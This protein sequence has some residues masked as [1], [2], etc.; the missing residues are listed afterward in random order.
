M[1]IGF[2]FLITIHCAFSCAEV[3][4][5]KEWIHTA[6]SLAFHEP[7]DTSK[8]YEENLEEMVQKNLIW[9]SKDIQKEVLNI[10]QDYRNCLME[11]EYDDINELKTIVNKQYEEAKCHYQPSSYFRYLINLEVYSKKMFS[12]L[13]NKQTLYAYIAEKNKNFKNEKLKGKEIIKFFDF[14]FENALELSKKKTLY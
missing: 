8:N 10:I 11:K 7:G 1:K 9:E 2:L 5:Y 12:K 6:A 4:A 13:H 14:H 3:E